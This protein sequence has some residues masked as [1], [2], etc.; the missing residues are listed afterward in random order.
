M[1]T[2]IPANNVTTIINILNNQNTKQNTI[3]EIVNI[4]HTVL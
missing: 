2:N 4:T 3:T 1:Y